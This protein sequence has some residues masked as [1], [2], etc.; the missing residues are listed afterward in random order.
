MVAFVDDD[1]RTIRVGQCHR[2]VQPSPNVKVRGIR[3]HQPSG[4]RLEIRLFPAIEPH[5]A[6]LVYF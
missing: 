1:R 5:L 4:L 3:N 2:P 6:L